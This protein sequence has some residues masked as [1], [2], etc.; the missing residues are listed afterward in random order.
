MSCEK[1]DSSSFLCEA[2]RNTWSQQRQKRR[3]ERIS[4]VC[5]P[6]SKRYCHGRTDVGC[7]VNLGS[8]DGRDSYSNAGNFTDCIVFSGSGKS[9]DTR[10]VSVQ[11]SF[12]FITLIICFALFLIEYNK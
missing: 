1:Q 4:G 5:P 7:T 9:G 6:L 2:V 12:K 3:A 10:D 11:V 8:G